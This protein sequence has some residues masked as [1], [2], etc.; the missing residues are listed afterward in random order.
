MYKGAANVSSALGGSE[1]R[2]AM[3]QFFRLELT[4]ALLFPLR[5]L[6][7]QDLAPRAYNGTYISSVAIPER[8]PAWQ[9][10]WLGRPN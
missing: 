2:S 6:R 3:Q 5:V 8:F 7:A 4:A 9:Y 1:I 10:S